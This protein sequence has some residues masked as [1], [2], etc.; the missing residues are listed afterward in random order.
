MNHEDQQFLINLAHQSGALAS[1]YADKLQIEGKPDGS[2]VTQADWK[3]E[4]LIRSQLAT[5]WPDDAI[6]GEEMPSSALGAML[7]TSSWKSNGAGLPARNSSRRPG[8]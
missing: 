6:I 5:R 2:L 1:Q 3:V 4:E 8:K 7:A